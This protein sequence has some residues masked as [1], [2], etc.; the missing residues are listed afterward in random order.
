MKSTAL[1]L[2]LGASAAVLAPAALAAQVQPFSATVNVTESV[3]PNPNP[4]P[5]CVLLGDVSG[6]GT[7]SV[8][9]V[10]IASQ[11]CIVPLSETG[12]FV[13]SS[14][15][16]V[17]TSRNGAMYGHYAGVLLPT[18]NPGVYTVA[19]T[20]WIT[21]GTGRYKHASG[22]GILTGTESLALGLGATG[23]IALRGILSY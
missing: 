11:D 13:F 4:T 2:A 1:A 10:S 3:A 7:A 20:Y 22:T 14:Q 5:A 12:P 16:I 18:G 19:G 8:G 23:T 21:G 9:D 6:T 17:L 15:D